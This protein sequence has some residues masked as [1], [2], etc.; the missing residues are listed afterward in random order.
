MSP[1]FCCAARSR[2]LHVVIALL[3]PI[4]SS[5]VEALT[6]RKAAVTAGLGFSSKDPL[7]EITSM[8][9]MIDR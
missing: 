4:E 1:D 3:I 2:S 6:H 7:F 5:D 8:W 9:C